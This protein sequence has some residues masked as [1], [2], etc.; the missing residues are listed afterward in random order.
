MQIRDEQRFSEQM[1]ALMDDLRAQV[2]SAKTRYELLEHCATEAITTPQDPLSTTLF[3]IQQLCKNSTNS[4]NEA[5]LLLQAQAVKA[6][7]EIDQ[8][9]LTTEQTRHRDSDENDD[10]EEQNITPDAPEEKHYSSLQDRIAEALQRKADKDFLAS[11]IHQRSA[12]DIQ[13]KDKDAPQAPS[14]SRT[15]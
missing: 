7:L 10:E 4:Q 11:Q 6:S 15:R 5:A 9:A 1:D 14:S 2:P 13:P 3:D 12:Q 8:I